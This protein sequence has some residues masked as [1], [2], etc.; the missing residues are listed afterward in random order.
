[1]TPDKIASVRGRC[2]V[3]CST[4]DDYHDL[5]ADS[6][7]C[8]GQL[9]AEVERLR[10]AI[11]GESHSRS[12]RDAV[13]AHLASRKCECDHD[14]GAAPCVT[15]AMREVL[16]WKVKLDTALRGEPVTTTPTPEQP[17]QSPEP[18]SSE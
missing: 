16:A 12:I 6:Y 3:G 4:L 5:A 9:Q 17:T 7:A 8:I 14:T 11:D 2:R 1:M 13:I 18:T 15:C 10:A